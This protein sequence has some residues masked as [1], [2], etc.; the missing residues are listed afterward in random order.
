MRSMQIHCWCFVRYLAARNECWR[1]AVWSLLN[2]AQNNQREAIIS[3]A[4]LP[5]LP[6][7]ASVI[8]LA[9]LWQE[10]F[11]SNMPNSPIFALKKMSAAWMFRA[12]HSTE[13]TFIQGKW[14][15]RVCCIFCFFMFIA[16]F[17]PQDIILKLLDSLEPRGT[18]N[19]WLRGLPP[20]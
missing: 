11:H 15:K 10:M 4:V 17:F 16:F 7:F 9:I 5:S 12:Q 19:L 1:N 8:D 14:M 6:Q 13:N 3:V 2:A 20:Y 18:V